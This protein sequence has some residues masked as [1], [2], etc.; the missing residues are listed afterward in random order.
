MPI[1]GSSQN[2]LCG[3]LRGGCSTNNKGVQEEP[4]VRYGNKRQQVFEKIK[5]VDIISV[6][7]HVCRL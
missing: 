6:Q 1:G 7:V 4:V 3:P 5:G 2:Q